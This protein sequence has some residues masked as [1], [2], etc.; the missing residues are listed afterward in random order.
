MVVGICQTDVV[1]EDKKYNLII[2]EDYISKCTGKGAKLVL[3]PEMS[4]TGYTMSPESVYETKDNNE[5]LKIMS[6]YA[7]KYN[8]A[9]G[10]GYVLKEMR[11]Y[12][13][14]YMIVDAKGTVI[15]DYSKI[16][17]FSYAGENKYYIS[18]DRIDFCE[19]DGVKICPLICYDL[20]FPELFQAASKEADLIVVAA[21]WPAQRN[22]NWK[23]LLQ[24]RALENQS[25]IIGVN[26][27]GKD[28]NDYYV[29]DSMM[30]DPR[31]QII[32]VLEDKA[33]LMMVD[34][35]KSAVREC[36]EEFPMKSDRRPDIYQKLL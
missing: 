31:G 19:V 13:N 29:G 22:A 35:D 4:M 33:G 11:G 6:G 32:D 8:T 17:P 14:R 16:H 5:T 15:C 9:V 1:M 20:R 30:V 36:R 28:E 23:L 2:A 34:I 24:A 25:Y 3:F 7:V 18:G 10:F 12:S 27:A 21:N 26:R